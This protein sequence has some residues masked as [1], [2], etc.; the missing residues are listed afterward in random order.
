MPEY[1]LWLTDDT[2]TRITLLTD[3][4][5]LFFFSYTRTTSGLGT[6]N[7]GLSFREFTKKLKPY[8]RPDWRVDIWRSPA[9]GVKMRRED[10]YMLRKPHVYTRDDGVEAI[11]FYGRNGIDLLNR[12]SIVQ[13][14]G[15]TYA[16]KTDQIDDF[17]KAI[18]RQQMLYG[19]ALDE[20]GVVDNTRAWP[21]NEFFVQSDV[22]LGPSITR[23]FAGRNVLEA[24]KDLSAISFQKNADSSSNRRIY[25]DV[26]PR[27]VSG[28]A[29]VTGAPLGWE[30]Q[31]F[32]DQR[33][34]DR[35]AGV[36][37]SLEN[38]N[39]EQPAYSISHLDEINSIFVTGN[40]QGSTQIITSVDDNARIQ[41]SRWNRVEKV[42]SAASETTTAALQDAGR[43]ELTK[44]KP[45]EDALITLLNSPGGPN[46]PRSLYGVDWDLGDLI[47]VNY[48]DKQMEMEINN[49]Y[50]GVDEN[51]QETITGRTVAR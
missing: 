12:R 48:A 27:D 1:E 50:V 31:T 6:V 10:V 17:M 20:D 24:L 34:S 45:V 18:V 39:V 9:P 28:S 15:T 47:P 36:V 33:G 43:N 19:S 11:Q 5:E 13:R 30:F 41:A 38:E 26:V 46:V 51:G 2:G 21:Q 14:A 23:D 7:F 49:I 40:G 37:F 29:T 16:K 4:R 22:S 3:T 25:F 32:V 8:F 35:T 44:G 42:M